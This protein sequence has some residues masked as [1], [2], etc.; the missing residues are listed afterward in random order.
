MVAV[1]FSFY[2]VV[3]EG[4][5]DVVHI[6]GDLLS[7]L[8]LVAAKLAGSSRVII[9]VHNADE[10]IPCR[11][12][13]FKPV[14]RSVFR[15]I[16][17]Q[18]SDRIVGI[19]NH[20]LNTF[21]HGRERRPGKDQVHYYGIDP[22]P[23]LEAKA[24]RAGFR[25]EL[26]VSEDALLLLF[27]GRMVPEKNPLFAVEVFAEM[28]KR[29]PNVYGVFAGAG[30]LEE[31]VSHR[32]AELGVT[33]AFRAL[34][35]RDDIPELM[36]CCDCF[37]LP[38]PE[39]PKEGLGIAVIEAQLAGLRMLLSKGISDDPI[40]P[41]AVCARLPLSEGADHWAEAGLELM[42]RNPPG[43]TRAAKILSG[44]PFDLDHAL[45]DLLSL[46]GHS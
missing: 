40:L 38:R 34:G 32:A 36:S 6:H 45:D 2:Q 11:E 17:L 19:S 46:H 4:K 15:T 27:A 8:Y 30:S 33:P 16:G 18:F 35:W 28:H 25:H 1:F 5:Y 37:I 24:D 14:I 7:A 3:R 12:S 29:N 31:V 39:Q 42:S 9:H 41:E 26:G 10:S 23:F 44:S 13:F 21:L 20:T 43:R 22:T